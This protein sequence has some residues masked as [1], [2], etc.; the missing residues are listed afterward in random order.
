MACRTF[1]TVL[2]E[3]CLMYLRNSGGSQSIRQREGVGHARET[4]IIAQAYCV[5]LSST[6]STLTVTSPF[7]GFIEVL[8]RELTWVD[9]REF[10]I[11]SQR[12]QGSL[13][14]GR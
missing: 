7:Y 12:T 8:L 4:S 3:L 10:G 13:Y 6:F 14:Y 1:Q 5:R 9:K 2:M 11:G